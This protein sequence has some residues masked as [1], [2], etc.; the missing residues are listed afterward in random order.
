MT[1]T[2]PKTFFLIDD[3]PIYQT[4]SKKII[5]KFQPEKTIN[6]FYNGLEAIEKL[7]TIESLPDI[8]LLDIEMPVMDGWDFM[9]QFNELKPQFPKEVLVYIVSSSIAADDQMRA[10]AF[11]S[12]SGYFS[13]PLTAETISEITNHRNVLE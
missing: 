1:T 3:D 9:K 8:I 7:R 6:S 5:S 10:K 12:I 2:T 11:P 4:I 13:K